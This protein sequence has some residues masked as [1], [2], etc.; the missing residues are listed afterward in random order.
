MAGRSIVHQ[1]WDRQRVNTWGLVFV[2]RA[3]AG[4]IALRTSVAGT[5]RD[6]DARRELI[7]PLD[8][9]IQPR[10][11]GGYDGELGKSV[12][13][14]QLCCGEMFSGLEVFDFSGNVTVSVPDLQSAQQTNGRASLGHMFPD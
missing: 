1:A 14:R 2:Q 3:V 12:H 7:G 9:R 5:H 4:V 10:A 8:S 6:T 13:Q 11:A